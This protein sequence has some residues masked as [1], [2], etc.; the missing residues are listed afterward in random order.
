MGLVAG[1]DGN[2]WFAENKGWA[3]GRMSMLGELAEFPVQGGMPSAI[4]VGPDENLW[5]TEDQGRIGRITSAGIVAEFLS[6]DSGLPRAISAGADGN[7]WF[8]G[9][10]GRPSVGRI[11]PA[12]TVETIPVPLSLTT[13]SPGMALGAA[14]AIWFTNGNS[15][16]RLTPEGTATAFP[17]ATRGRP[18]AIVAGLNSDLWFSEFAGGVGRITLSGEI[19]ESAVPADVYAGYGIAVGPDGDVWFTEA[20]PNKIGRLSASGTFV[21]YDIPTAGSFPYGIAVAADGSVWFTEKEVG[22]IGRIVP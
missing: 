12:G 7:L 1:P 19:S 22:K 20:G 4:T 11:S 17:A 13:E 9:I 8:A 5:F 18:Q 15:I 2:L 21:E 6:G 10:N 3:I 14:G 16:I